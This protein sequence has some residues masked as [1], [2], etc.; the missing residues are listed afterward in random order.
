MPSFFHTRC[1]FYA[2][3]V[4]C[5]PL[6][7]I[8]KE[9]G[10]HCS[11]SHSFFH[12]SSFQ[13]IHLVSI[14]PLHDAVHCMEI[15]I[16]WLWTW[17]RIER[18]ACSCFQNSSSRVEM[19][20]V[21]TEAIGHALPSFVL[22]F[23]RIEGWNEHSCTSFIADDEQSSSREKGDGNSGLLSSSRNDEERC[24]QDHFH[25]GGECKSEHFGARHCGDRFTLAPAL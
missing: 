1:A 25:G 16:E 7:F 6:S 18:N 19:R 20:I 22:F 8:L 21:F 15:V 23:T 13:S 24:R 14:A 3:C 5:I 4:S 11:I 17:S 2:L 10:N 9:N 12:N